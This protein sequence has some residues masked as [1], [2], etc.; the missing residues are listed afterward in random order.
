MKLLYIITL[1]TLV[2]CQ[3]HKPKAPSF[4]E[5]RTEVQDKFAL[6]TALQPSVED[7]NGWILTAECD[8][9]LFTS[10]NSVSGRKPNLLVARADNGQWF[11]RPLTYTPCYPKNSGSSISRDML[12]GLMYATYRSRNLGIA[13]DLFDY[14]ESRG[15][16]MGQG[17][18][19]RTGFTPGLQATLAEIIFRISGQD[20]I[21]YRGLPQ[22]WT[23]GLTDYQLHLNLLH[24]ALRGELFGF[25]SEPMK[26]V[27]AD[28]ASREPNNALAA[29]LH[30]KY[31]SGDLTHTAG[32]LL[33]EAWWPA[34]RLPNTGDRKTE[35]LN[36]RSYLDSEGQV[37]PD[38][39]PV[40]GTANPHTG[41]DFLFVAKL[42]LEASQ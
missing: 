42:F 23:T 12:L 10:L 21:F 14:G 41:G 8:A 30:A 38:W 4:S 25:I 5:Q 28:A 13:T 35:W 15:W 16:V 32:L 39:L 7:S 31:I 27:I 22:I 3:K 19:T 34:D 33:N 40:E 29:V 26:D 11:R 18:I 24:V 2:A 9:L 20:K 37:N 6:Y 1:L 36:Q 17:E